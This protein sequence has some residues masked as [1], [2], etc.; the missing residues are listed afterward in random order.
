MSTG[1]PDRVGRRSQELLTEWGDTHENFGQSGETLR[2]P[3]HK[4]RGD[5]FMHPE[6]FRHNHTNNSQRP[7]THS[8]TTVSH[9]KP[10]HRQQ[11]P[12]DTSS[13]TTVSH[14]HR[15][16]DRS[17]PATPAH[18]QQSATDTGSRTEVS[19]R[20][21]LTDNS[22]PPT[23]AHG[24]QLAL[25]PSVAV[26]AATRQAGD[27]SGHHGR[28]VGTRSWPGTTNRSSAERRTKPT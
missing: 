18:R 10:T 1:T 14:R 6:L 20:H 25:E 3:P 26:K 24:Q 7:K 9:R 17:Q 19:H 23:P 5:R 21:R 2:K 11:S 22:Q 16:T 28:P 27:T 8:Q 4:V 13:Q 15:L 12:T